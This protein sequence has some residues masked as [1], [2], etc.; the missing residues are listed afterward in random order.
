MREASLE[1][2]GSE[3]GVIALRDVHEG[4]VYRHCEDSYK[5]RWWAETYKKWAPPVRGA[6]INVK[7]NTSKQLLPWMSTLCGLA[8]A[9][10]FLEA[11]IRSCHVILGAWT[12]THFSVPGVDHP[13]LYVVTCVLQRYLKTPKRRFRG[14]RDMCS[15]SSEIPLQIR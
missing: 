11:T 1:R 13:A 5:L 15:G 4:Y 7:K 6:K 12:G 2:D 9:N 8:K 14:C 10:F 3:R